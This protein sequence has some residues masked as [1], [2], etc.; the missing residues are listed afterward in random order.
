[1]SGGGKLTCLTFF[2]STIKNKDKF[3]VKMVVVTW[4]D[5]KTAF[6]ISYA[7]VSPDPSAGRIGIRR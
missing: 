7:T 1:M 6:M 2:F 4:K 5:E 3:K